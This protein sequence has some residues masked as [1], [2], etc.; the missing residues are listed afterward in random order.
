MLKVKLV[1]SAISNTPKNRATVKALGLKKVQQTVTHEDNSTIRGM[2]FKVKH[3]L[4]VSEAPG[5]KRVVKSGSINAKKASLK[6][7]REKLE[8]IAAK[9][10]ASVKKP[11]A[12]KKKAT[13]EAE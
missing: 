12:K 8:A 4:E 11:A 5:E 13:K 1:K 2:I 3:L 10:E 6:S 7:N 9:A